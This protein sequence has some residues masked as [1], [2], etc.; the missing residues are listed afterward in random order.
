[1]TMMVL[2]G[3]VAGLASQD[4][5]PEDGYIVLQ[6]AM[7]EFQHSIE[8]RSSGDLAGAHQF[9][10]YAEKALFSQKAAVHPDLEQPVCRQEDFIAGM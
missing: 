2:L 3:V 9:F 1:M 6:A 4:R 10:V 8:E 7:A 5:Y